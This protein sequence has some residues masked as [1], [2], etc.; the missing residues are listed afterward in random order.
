MS[1][2]DQQINQES[3]R[4]G[5]SV[6]YRP[7]S[8]EQHHPEQ[9]AGLIYESSPE[10]FSLMFG[11]HG[12]QSLTRLVQ[13]DYNRFSYQY[14]RVAQIDEQVV[15]VAVMVPAE[16]V[17]AATDFQTLSYRQQLRLG[18]V[19]RLIVPFVLQQNYP[20]GSFY[21]GNLAVDSRYRN[22]GIGQQLL[23]NCIDEAAASS[24]SIYISV[25]VDNVRAQKLY[26]S[27]GFQ[28]VQEKVIRLGGFRVGSLVLAVSP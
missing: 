23:L 10:L 5:E 16:K 28:L 2:Q 9:V 13:G 24:G 11:S 14:V 18:L 15:G 7:M 22:Q 26:Q 3:N 21:I 25:D 20:Q 8:L 27:M 19:K 12:I 17:H 6:D 1:S 4:S